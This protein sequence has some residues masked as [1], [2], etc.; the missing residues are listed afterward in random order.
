MFFRIYVV[1]GLS[2]LLRITVKWNGFSASRRKP[3]RAFTFC[4]VSSDNVAD[5]P[6]STVSRRNNLRADLSSAYLGRNSSPYLWTRWSLSIPTIP[7][8]FLQKRIMSRI[9][10]LASCSGL[11]KM[12]W[13]WLARMLPSILRLTFLFSAVILQTLIMS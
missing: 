13:Y 8:R 2:I 6:I 11:K 7:I 5:A 12:Y 9:L 4:S 10:L 3:A 1:S